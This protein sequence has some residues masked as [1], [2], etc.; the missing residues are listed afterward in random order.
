MYSFRM[1][2]VLLVPDCWCDLAVH[3][4]EYYWRKVRNETEYFMPEYENIFDIVYV[5]VHVIGCECQVRCVSQS[6]LWSHWKMPR[7]E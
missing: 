5:S 3:G 2:G 6:P 7:V 4:I 1:N